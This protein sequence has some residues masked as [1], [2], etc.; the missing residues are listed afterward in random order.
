MTSA[1]WNRF[2]T[3]AA[4]HPDKAA[5]IYF[6]KGM[7]KTVTYAQLLDLSNRFVLGFQALRS[8]SHRPDALLGGQACSATPGMR[9]AVM[10]PPSVDFFA[11]AFAMLK[12]GIIPIIV[13]PAIGLKKLGECLKESQPD[14]FIGNTLTHTLRDYLWLGKRINQTQPNHQSIITNYQLRITKYSNLQSPTP[15]FPRRHYLYQWKYR[16]PQRCALH[17]RQLLCAIGYVADHF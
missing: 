7:W 10:T 6:H 8:N 15:K 12:L 1:I 2:E 5:L 16:H 9:A 11:L 17:S 14:I 4:R 13:D 3:N